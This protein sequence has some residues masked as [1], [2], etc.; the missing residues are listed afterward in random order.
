MRPDAQTGRRVLLAMLLFL[1]A[2]T[3]RALEAPTEVLVVVDLPERVETGVAGQEPVGGDPSASGIDLDASV[4][5][6]VEAFTIPTI[7]LALPEDQ[8]EE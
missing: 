7:P 5:S 3:A 1:A 8:R 2:A 6:D 4:F